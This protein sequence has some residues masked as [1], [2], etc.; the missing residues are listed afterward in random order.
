MSIS[1]SAI[2]IS[3]TVNGDRLDGEMVELCIRKIGQMI[4]NPTNIF[5]KGFL[6]RQQETVIGHKQFLCVFAQIA[7]SECSYYLDWNTIHHSRLPVFNLL[8]W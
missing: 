4:A 7:V 8:L 3:L 5:S 6:R 2:P 1:N